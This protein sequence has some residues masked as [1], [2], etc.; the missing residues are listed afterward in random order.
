MKVR[1][2]FVSNSSSSS[3]IVGAKDEKKYEEKMKAFLH[4]KFGELGQVIYKTLLDPV[5]LNKITGIA[6]D[7]GDGEGI[8]LA[9][10]D[11]YHTAYM[12]SKEKYDK[13]VNKGFTLY[14]GLVNPLKRFSEITLTMT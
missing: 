12:E 14:Y 3:F 4:L 1:I 9:T 11:H 5:M 13:L 2:G 8:E 6:T 7:Y 10:T